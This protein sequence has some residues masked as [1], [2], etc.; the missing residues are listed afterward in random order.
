MYHSNIQYSKNSLH[1]PKAGLAIPNPLRDKV[2]LVEEL[3]GH[4]RYLVDDQDV[5]IPPPLLAVLVAHDAGAHVGDGSLG[6]PHAGEA[7]DGDAA[8]VAGGNARGGRD[9]DLAGLAPPVPEGVPFVS[10]EADDG[11]QDVRFAGAGGTREEDRVAGQDGLD[12]VTLLGTEAGGIRG[13]QGDG[14]RWILHG[15]GESLHVELAGGAGAGAAPT[16]VAVG[17]APSSAARWAIRGDSRGHAGHRRPSD[18]AA[19]ARCLLLP[20]K[21]ASNPFVLVFHPVV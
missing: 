16:I 18:S 12:D 11:G 9:G 19:A 17:I 2:E 3:S 13:G 10:E 1:P 15:L 4:H 6:G 14:R 20:I 5:V 21:V 7:V 8:D